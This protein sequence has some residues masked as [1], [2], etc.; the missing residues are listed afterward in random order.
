[1]HFAAVGCACD[2]L[3][4][5][6]TDRAR[7]GVGCRHL[8]MQQAALLCLFSFAA[9]PPAYSHRARSPLAAATKPRA[10]AASATWLACASRACCRRTTPPAKA[11]HT[12]TWQPSALPCH[13]RPRLTRQLP[14]APTMLRTCLWR[15]QCCPAHV[16]A[17]L[18][19]RP[20]APA[21]LPAGTAEPATM[22][23]HE[24]GSCGMQ[25]AVEHVACG[26]TSRRGYWVHVLIGWLVEQQRTEQS[27][28]E[29]AQ[30]GG[31]HR[32]GQQPDGT[33]PPLTC[34]SGRRPWRPAPRRPPPPPR[35]AR[36]CCLPRLPTP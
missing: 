36:P 4:T 27:R 15:P 1:M 11:W 26:V 24:T 20:N 18:R 10:S 13:P 5:H 23:Q 29:Q 6:E 3:V 17:T 2:C 9:P 30:V 22:Q 12:P 8:V 28:N 34:V 19:G 32:G 7:E 25:T 16:L 31:M 14:V 33:L 21:L 35:A